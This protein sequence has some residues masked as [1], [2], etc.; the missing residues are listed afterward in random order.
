MG[1]TLKL[2]RIHLPDQPAKDG[3]KQDKTDEN[4]AQRPFG[5]GHGKRLTQTDLGR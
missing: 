5:N 3:N 4:K 2:R 1:I